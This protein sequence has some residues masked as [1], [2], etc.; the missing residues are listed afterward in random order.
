MTTTPDSSRGI[1]SHITAPPSPRALQI[2][3]ATGVGS[4]L[5]GFAYRDAST[6]ASRR[7]R[8]LRVPFQDA[9]RAAPGCPPSRR[10][11]LSAPTYRRTPQ[12]AFA[13]LPSPAMNK[14]GGEEGARAAM[15]PR[16]AAALAAAVAGAAVALAAASRSSARASPSSPPPP[17][18]PPGTSPSST[19]ASPFPA[20]N[21][22]P[23]P[24][25]ASTRH[26][27]PRRHVRRHRHLEHPRMARARPGRRRRLRLDGLGI[28]PGAGVPGAS[29]ARG[30]AAPAGSFT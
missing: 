30:G 18:P 5:G 9:A 2:Y 29:A 21:P 8:S 23:S 27:H 3:R 16:T 17:R 24:P 19:R 12:R 11:A 15:R 25:R 4:S 10:S 14:G 6:R 13:S 20:R 22:P 1:P 7:A 28:V 26:R